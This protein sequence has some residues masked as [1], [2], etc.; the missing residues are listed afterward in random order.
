M[1]KS[2]VRFKSYMV[3]T[4][5]FYVNAEPH[6]GHLYSIIIADV[7]ARYHKLRYPNKQIVFSTGT[8]E[9]GL[10][11]QQAAMELGV[12]PKELCDEIS[13][14][15][16]HLSD[17][18]NSSY[19][20]FI[21][22]TDQ[23][24]VINVQKLWME[25]WNKNFIYKGTHEGWYAVSDEAFYP[26]SS[27][28]DYVNEQTGEC[29][30]I[31]IETG[32]K[33][34]WMSETN[35]KFRLSDFRLSLID[36]LK[37]NPKAIHPMKIYN[38]VLQSLE[39]FESAVNDLSIS[40]PKSRLNWGITVPNDPDHTIYV[41]IDA[42]A[43][44]LTVANDHNSWPSDIHVV[45]KD[46][47]RFHAIYWP[48]LLLAAGLN[49][50]KTILSHAHWTMNGQKMSKSTGNVVDPFTI[51]EK[52][53]PDAI[54]YYLLRVGG[55]FTNDADFK[56][57][58]LQQ[59]YKSTLQGMLG[60]LLS[61]ISGKKIEKKLQQP[62]LNISLIVGEKERNLNELLKTLKY[63]FGYS[64]DNFELSKAIQSVEEVLHEVSKFSLYNRMI[65]NIN[66]FV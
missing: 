32:K 61:R 11:V 44:Y 13:Y 1:F 38:N 63:K 59:K 57:L 12:K 48:A 58:E 19:T 53:S 24:H 43:N 27:I 8:D 54:R 3:T 49:L 26:D 14:R 51:M 5:I 42:L 50:P 52:F 47:I 18:S 46:I 6:I 56:P 40:R 62:N 23:N 33:V 2:L 28:S 22:T 39:N 21:R 9:H 34:E 41:W 7:L 16:K 4:P 36:W 20:N 64:F 10:K 37:H 66:F 17:V 45:G 15:F 60:N 31:S 29:Y 30:K 55:N 65:F 35:Y 25:L